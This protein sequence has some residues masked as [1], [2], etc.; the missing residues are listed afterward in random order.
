MAQAKQSFDVVV[1]GG[2][3]G[4]YV[5]AIRSAQLGL[6]TA[7]IEGHKLGG[8]CL[9]YG[10]I[11]SKAMITTGHLVDRIRHADKQGITVTGL[12]VDLAKLVDWKGGVVKQLTGGVGSLLKANGVTVFKGQGSFDSV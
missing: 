4:G 3:P 10:C 8:E 1:I 5:C 6:K 7:I 12:N 11:P 2:G 9:N